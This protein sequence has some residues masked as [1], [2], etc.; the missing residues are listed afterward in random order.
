MTQL[1]VRFGSVRFGYLDLARLGSKLSSSWLD[2]WFG[3]ARGLVRLNSGIVSD[4]LRLKPETRYP[5]Q[6]CSKLESAYRKARGSARCSTLS[7][8]LLNSKTFLEKLGARLHLG[9]GPWLGSGLVSRL[10]SGLVSRLGSGLVSSLGSGLR[11]A[12]GFVRTRPGSGIGS[13][14]LGSA[15]DSA[16]LTEPIA[17]Y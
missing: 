2:A 4:R 16:G 10:G 15:R 12:L 8:A 11:I 5:A 13:L 3:E 9:S 7:S 1:G 14:G 17:Q 6:L